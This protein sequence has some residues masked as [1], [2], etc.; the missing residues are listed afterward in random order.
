MEIIHKVKGF[1]DIFPPRSETYTRLEEAARQIFSRYGF[2]ELRLPLLEKTE[3]FA[4]SIGDETD[5]VQKEMYSFQDRKGRSL[6][7]R[8]E[9]TAG[10]ARAYIENKIYAGQEVSKLYTLGPMFRY[11]RPQKGRQRQFHQINAEILGSA[12]PEADA[13]LLL[14]LTSFLKNIGLKALVLDLNSL[15]CSKCRPVFIEAVDA[16]LRSE[17]RAG[18]CPDCQQRSQTNPLRTYD[19]K[20]DRCRENMKGAPRITDYI[21]LDCRDHFQVVKD[22]LD[23]SGVEYRIN[24]NLVRG[25]DYYQRTTFEV[26]SRDIGSQSAVAG[27]GR[28]DGLLKDLGG[29]DLPGIGFACGLERLV[30]LLGENEPA[31]CD[32]FV[33]VLVPEAKETGLLLACELREQGLCGETGFEVK[34]L[35]SQLR[36]ANKHLARKCLILG[37]E[38]MAGSTVLAKDMQTGEQHEVAREKALSIFDG[39]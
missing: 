12:A 29:P 13:E 28:Y 36:L 33:A 35:K 24:P 10:V 8:P 6:T 30:M 5:I 9:A 26:I 4:R 39:L 22:L 17:E 16:F 27:G 15:G 23:R 34:S 21:C 31:G 3:L 37:Q 14:M 7:L 19:C 18:F 38:E 11:E 2:G 32:F 25:L 1:S 20:V